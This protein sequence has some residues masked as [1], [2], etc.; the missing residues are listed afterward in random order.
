MSQE[1]IFTFIYICCITCWKMLHYC[2]H[3]SRTEHS[4]CC[5]FCLFVMYLCWKSI[6]D[7]WRFA[8]RMRMHQSLSMNISFILLC[9]ILGKLR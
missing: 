5:S 3:Q 7:L 2:H 1:S 4:L 9:L 8:L 6:Q